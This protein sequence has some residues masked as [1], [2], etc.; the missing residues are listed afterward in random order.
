MNQSHFLA[1]IVTRENLANF[2][3]SEQ[4][5][6]RG[7][8]N[9]ILDAYNSL[10][11]KQVEKARKKTVFVFDSVFHA[12]IDLSNRD[13]YDIRILCLELQM[14]RPEMANLASFQKLIVPVFVGIEKKCDFVVADCQSQTMV[15]PEPHLTS[16]R[17]FFQ[18]YLHLTKNERL[19]ESRISGQ[20]ATSG[21]SQKY[22][23]CE[24]NLTLW[25]YVTTSQFV[26]VNAK[27][28]EM[29]LRGK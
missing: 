24:D 22:K 14:S 23:K 6:T 29:E 2:M 18:E 15:G 4:D 27:E 7:G 19:A 21:A 28:K 11:Y 5:Q 26:S 3:R 25:K 9:Q 8:S 13:Q 17:A 10:I 12:K 16:F 20:S 1:S